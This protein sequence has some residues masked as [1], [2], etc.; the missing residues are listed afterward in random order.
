VKSS[1]M[2]LALVLLGILSNV[3]AQAQAP[4]RQGIVFV[5]DGSGDTTS[6]TDNLGPIL[7]A[8]GYAVH[9]IRW[10][11]WGQ[12]AKDHRDFASQVSAGECLARKIAAHRASFPRERIYLIGFSAGT[13]VILTATR[14]LP[15]EAVDR[16]VL[17]APTVSQY[18]DLRPA[19]RCSRGGIECFWSSEDQVA[20]TATDVLGNAD[21]LPGRA[22]GE[23]GFAIMPAHYPDAHLYNKL[24]QYAWSPSWRHWGH[25]GGHSAFTDQP[26]LAGAVMP[27]MLA[28]ETAKR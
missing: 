22:A 4:E 19:L 13:H 8:H 21:R 1:P 18:H 14:S 24:R 11:Q 12:P 6:I 23:R 9:T 10:S 25:R 3:P 16:I 15:E 5:A 28:S 27:I 7:H 17:L 20:P 2:C 26:F